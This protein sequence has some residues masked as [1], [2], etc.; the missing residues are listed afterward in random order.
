MSFKANNQEEHTFNFTMTTF[1]FLKV[2]EK[3]CDVT[4]LPDEW[5]MV[6]KPQKVEKQSLKTTV[7]DTKPKASLRTLLNGIFD[8]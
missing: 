4:D 6:S 5:C 2:D 1:G 8:E 7:E 3:L